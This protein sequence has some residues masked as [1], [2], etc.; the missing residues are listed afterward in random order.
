M[1]GQYRQQRGLRAGTLGLGQVAH[2]LE[3]SCEYRIGLLM[4]IA[5][6]RDLRRLLQV[7]D[8]PRPVGGL[9]EVI[10]QLGHDVLYALRVHRGQTLAELTMKRGPASRQLPVVENL[11]VQRVDEFV[12]LGHARS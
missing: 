2:Q 6:S 9:L 5:A 7:V 10:G 8:G 12:A 4:S 3:S 11:P 1:R